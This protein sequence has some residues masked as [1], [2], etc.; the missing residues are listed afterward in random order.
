MVGGL[1]WLYGSNCSDDN[2]RDEPKV[3]LELN[4]TTLRVII[5][6]VQAE[7]DLAPLMQTQ[8]QK[9]PSSKKAKDSKDCK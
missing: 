9:K 1:K 2:K 4:G 8:A 3:G 6:G 5:D 7:V